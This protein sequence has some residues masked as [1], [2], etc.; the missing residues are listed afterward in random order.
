MLIVIVVADALL[1]QRSMEKARR[2]RLLART[3][4]LSGGNDA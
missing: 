2:Q 1:Q 4:A 3:S